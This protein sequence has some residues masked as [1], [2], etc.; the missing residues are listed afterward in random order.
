M[1]NKLG[2][3]VTSYGDYKYNAKTGTLQQIWVDYEPKVPCVVAP[4]EST[5]PLPLDVW[6]SQPVTF[7]N[8]NFIVLDSLQWSRWQ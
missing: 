6:T 4:C 7:E 2:M 5:A 1:K 3:S 8:P